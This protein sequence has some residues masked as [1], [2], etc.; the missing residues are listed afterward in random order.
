MMPSCGRFMKIGFFNTGF[1]KVTMAFV[2]VIFIVLINV[3]FNYYIIQKNKATIKQMTEAINPYIASLEELNLVVTESKMYATN[4][5]YLQNS[6]DDKK[7]LDSLH[8]F[9]HPEVKQKLNAFLEKLDKQSDKD[10]LQK[11]FKKFDALIAVE[12]DIMATLVSFDDYENA[13]K[14]FKCEEIIESEILPRTQAIM[15]DLDK[16]VDR[17][18]EE[19]E[20]MKTDIE[21]ASITRRSPRNISNR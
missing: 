9:H 10:S 12:K 16:I 1:P 21:R 6:M 11:V 13:Q 2:L 15:A 18:R 5:V 17:S 8:K 3:V 19:A 7:S 4:W 14:K 20:R